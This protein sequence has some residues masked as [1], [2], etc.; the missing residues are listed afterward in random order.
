MYANT[1]TDRPLGKEGS[2]WTPGGKV[3]GFEV[4]GR[5]LCGVLTQACVAT[6]YFPLGG[7][8]ELCHNN[9]LNLKGASYRPSESG[10]ERVSLVLKSSGTPLGRNNAE[11]GNRGGGDDDAFSSI[12]VGKRRDES[13]LAPHGVVVSSASCP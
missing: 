2:V 8:N 10:V 5:V 13:R 12:L 11:V 1:L 6:S 7:S 4:L 3:L 9:V